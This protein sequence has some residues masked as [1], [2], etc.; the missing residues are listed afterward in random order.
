MSDDN[1]VATRH[2][3]S[4]R[5]PARSGN[6][7]PLH[8]P[9]SPLA[10]VALAPAVSISDARGDSHT[11]GPY[12]AG[13]ASEYLLDLWQRGWLYADVMRERGNQYLKH[14]EQVVPH[15]LSFA[16]ELVILGPSL[17]RPVN[18]GLVRILP[19]NDVAADP[20]KR[21]FVIVDPRAG[22]GPGIGGFKAD[23][24]IGVALRAGH[25]CYFIGFAPDPVPGQTI[26]DVMR[27]IA[28]FLERVIELHQQSDGKP[29]VVGNC[30]A[31]WLVLMT[32]AVRPELF[33]PLIVAGAPVS[34]WAGWTGKNPM[35]YTAGLLGGSWMTALTSDLGAG[36]FDGASLVQN[37][38]NLNP[39]NTL[40]T[41]QYNLFANVD[42]ERDRYLGFERYWG[43][44]VLLNDVEIQ[45]IVD[46]L[47]IGNK[48][49]NAEMVTSD[50]VRID[51][52]NIRSPILVFCSYGDNITPPPQALGWITDLYFDEE[53]VLAHDQTI[54]YALHDT[55]GHLGIF[56]SGSVG[57]K[58]HREFEANIDFL[59]SLPAGIYQAEL[60][61]KGP[62]T[63]NPDLALGDYV[64]GLARRRLLDVRQIVSPDIESDRRFAAVERISE[65]NRSLYQ[66]FVQ[67]WIRA[68]IT[69]QLGQ[70]IRRLQPLRLSYE[71]NSD[72]APWAGWV[73]AEAERQRESRSPCAADNPF[74][75]LQEAISDAIE[76]SL[77]QWRAWRDSVCEQTFNAVY[78]S[79]W[80]QAWA[81]M[82][83]RE[84][85]EPRRHPGD[86][87]EHRAFLAAEAERL[88]NK[89]TE[90]GLIE[91]GLRSL[92]HVM[93][94]TS[95]VD[96]RVFNLLRRIR[97]ESGIVGEAITLGN[98][99]R[100]V[101]E[102]IGMMRR[103]PAEAIAALPELLARIESHDLAKM[104][105]A[106]G[107]LLTVGGPLDAAAQERLDEIKT[108]MS[109]ALH[110]RKFRGRI[111]VAPTQRAKSASKAARARRTA[112]PQQK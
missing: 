87:P 60:L 79:P 2:R 61:E 48:L 59:D 109:A 28:I 6:S 30:Q 111:A 96:A 107:R 25:P 11:L 108:M 82:N 45:Y 65:I 89:T 90:G 110:R 84:A 77:D 54:I 9:R 104:E 10:S 50:G 67:P 69:P 81:G 55:I 13:A 42:S 63:L 99:K 66:T 100:A 7:K 74:L 52:R 97:V 62:E 23:S 91:A 1:I 44:H 71:L 95:W 76:Q 26:E 57:R 5:E 72:Q 101:R 35:R 75:H 88:R 98:F 94:S 32:A 33:G 93:G 29:A 78:G 36:R 106:L 85:T 68:A 70:S 64:L 103:Y 105:E 47:F 14:I 80:V 73:A 37:F 3:D 17:A 102:Q 4:D 49:S 46:N 34:Y 27:A 86:T 53:D 92:Y 83:A 16:Y 12:S 21:P 56:V 20:K 112:L 18:Y 39:A 15:V 40:W 19:L 51:L 22:H 38:E 24:E 58:E 31:G 43:G 41:K 8:V